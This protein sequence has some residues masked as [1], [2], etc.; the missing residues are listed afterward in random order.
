M[1]RLQKGV[2][3]DSKTTPTKQ[4]DT[5]SEKTQTYTPATSGIRTHDHSIREEE[6]NYF[7]S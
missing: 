1:V 4:R 7:F 5:N 2:Q 6:K 3:P